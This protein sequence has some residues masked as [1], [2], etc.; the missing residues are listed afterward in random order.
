MGEEDVKINIKVW[1]DI[2]SRLLDMYSPEDSIRFIKYLIENGFK[3]LLVPFQYGHEGDLEEA[4]EIVSELDQYAESIE[5][6]YFEREYTDALKKISSCSVFVGMRLH[7]IILS[8]LLNIPFVGISYH[9][10]VT[11]LIEDLSMSKYYCE[12]DELSYEKLKRLFH[13][14]LDNYSEIKQ[15]LAEKLDRKRQVMEAKKEEL[16]PIFYCIVSNKVRKKTFF[17]N[18]SFYKMIFYFLSK[19]I[20]RLLS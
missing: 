16:I 2:Q 18:L 6:I 13:L 11:S 12:I 1:E 9:P 14:I 7:S 8:T 15:I 20:K 4:Q 19:R 17:L 3:V 10:K 5:I